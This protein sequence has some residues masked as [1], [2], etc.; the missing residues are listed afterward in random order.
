M[1]KIT[2]LLFAIFT[3]WQISAQVSS[4]A[5]SQS[6]GTYT[7]IT[8]G[9]VLG[10]ATND[11]TSFPA[12]PIGFSFVFNGVSHTQIGIQSNGWISLSGGTMTNS[13]NPLSTGAINNVIS[14]FGGD[15]QG[16]TVSGELSYQ[17]SGAAP[18]Q[19]L[20]IQWKDYR[21]FASTGDIY[22]FQIKLYETTNVIEMIYGSFTQN[23]TNRTREVGLRGA[24]NAAF[25]NR[26]TTTNWSATTAGLTNNANCT[27][28]TA[29]TPSSGLT[30]TWT[31]PTCPGST[32]LTSTNIT[33]TSATITW[34]EP[35]SIPANGYEYIVSSSA[36]TPIGAGTANTTNTAAVTSLTQNTNYFVFVRSICGSDIGTWVLVGG[37]RTLCDD[38]TSFFQNFDSPGQSTVF[39]GPLPDC[40]TKGIVGSPSLN[41]TT[42]S[43]AP[44]SPANRLIMTASAA[45]TVPSEAYAIL[46]PVSNLQAN[47]H[48]LRFK[49]FATIA[50]RT[51]SVGY[52]TDV[53][54]TVSF[55]ELQQLTLPG[56]TAAA[57]LEF[58]VVPGALPA[59]VKH[60]AIRNNGFFGTP[61]G[62]TTASFDDFSWEAIPT[63][64]EPSTLTASAI[65]NTTA[66][67]GWTEAS[68]ATAWEIQYGA[69]GFALGTGTIVPASTNPFILT[70][71]TP[72][73]N[74]T[75]YVRAVCSP[76]DSSFWIGPLA[77]KTQCDDVTSFFQNFEA[78]GQSTAFNGP[79]PDCWTKGQVGTPTFYVVA[80]SALPMSPPNRMI[81]TVSSTTTPPQQAYAILPSVSNLNAGTHRLRL[82]A[83]ATQPNRFLE[84]G[85]MTDPSNLS[86]FVFLT[87]FQIPGNVVANTQQ[88]IYVP[89]TT[90]IPAGVKHLA[91][92]NPG[93]PGGASSISIDDVS[94]EVIPTC[95]EPTGVSV[96]SVLATSATVNWT[97]ASPAP[98]EGYEYFVSTSST[99]PTS[100]TV[101]TGSVGAGI[102]TA[103]LTA[104]NPTT[105]YYVWVRS[106]CSASDKSAWTTIVTFTTPCAI[107]TPAYLEPF[108][109]WSPFPVNTPACWERYATGDQLTGP[110]G[111]VNSGSWNQDGYLNVGSTG[112]A[113]INIWTTSVR[114]WL[115][116]PVF[117]LAAGGY[118]VKYKVGVTQWNGTGPITSGPVATMGT[119]DFV[120]VL[121]STDGGTTW[122]NLTTYNAAN[123]PSLVGA[124]ATFNIPTVTSNTVRFAFYATSGTVSEG[125]D[126]DF[127]IDDFEV[128]SIPL[129]APICSTNVTAVPN[130]NCGNEATNIS[131]NA[132]AGA[133]GYKLTIGTTVGGSEVLNNL[134]VG[135]LTY[136]FV[137]N[138]NT[139]YYY[140]VVPFNANGDATGCAEQ[141]FSTAVTGCA[142]TPIYTSGV[143]SSD[144][145]SNLVVTGTTLSNNSGTSTTAPSY[146]LFVGQ[147]NYTATFVEGTTYTFQVTTGFGNQGFA[148]W[149]DLDNDLTFEPSEK[150]A[151]TETVISGTT[152]S[153]TFT[154]MCDPPAGQ[155]RMRV[156]MVYNTNGPLIDP[157]ASYIW[158][159]TEDYDVTLVPL[160]PPTGDAVQ[161]VT[162]A[163]AAE[164][165]IEDLVVT[166]TALRWFA[167]QADALANANE[168]PAGTLITDGTTYYAAS[169]EG[170]C[171]SLPLAVTANVTLSVGG[172]DNA[173]FKYYPN[174]VTDVLTVS[175]S[176]V[177]SDVVVYN[178]LG[179]QMLTSKPNATQTQVD[180]SSLT[181]GTYMVKV[182]SDEVSK[183]IKVVK[184]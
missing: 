63:C 183:T 74:Y 143:S 7:A 171:C 77:F 12:I 15:L 130:A 136:S 114:G 57:A 101:A 157:C 142:C 141:S 32:G 166:A 99:A 91:I 18:N 34:T 2:L 164:A 33:S 71:L 66:V 45:S 94:W 84:L 60:L 160:D 115:V 163:T 104:L 68:T 168:L 83:F 90:A 4:Y 177:I 52:M 40:W 51:V 118:Q 37:F 150:I 178:L 119:D 82:K 170:I 23:A 156:R 121:M 43:V 167:T 110:T 38:V 26:T 175:Y 180:L 153:F 79:L 41:V 3:C 103:A 162:A 31:P 137:A 62:S 76:T 108:T 126:Y 113:R 138:A 39:N 14:A 122:T 27:L 159:E 97:A 47:T 181:A 70:A 53:S 173:N 6:A 161:T 29:I 176:N 50:N 28:T 165:T 8:G 148:V 131:W 75:Y 95:L 46:P 129:T 42:G 72:N 123:T 149:V 172:F 65:T 147:P 36:T 93:F 146:T 20:T 24:S 64:I 92:L 81:M 67:L 133:D 102:T 151:T 125:Q 30:F 140:K 88:F 35:T 144:Y 16:N 158:G 174:P 152:G 120:Y 105:Q 116:S 13:W 78:P 106:V 117:N 111:A 1:K 109:S 134:V 21:H 22:N 5:F 98:A 89:S 55:V 132:S 49:G 11:D 54:N 56:T 19:V 124:T 69:P 9:T 112:A 155:Y 85:Y 145:L 58:I 100:A 127:F 179:Q 59:G 73:T 86:T 48:R 96:T 61:L 135:G 139:T 80:G 184:N 17:L 25:A 154:L 87:D 44:M 10:V 107:Y 169:S 182:T 128:L